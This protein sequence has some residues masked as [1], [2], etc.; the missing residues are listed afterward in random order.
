[1]YCYFSFFFLYILFSFL[2]TIIDVIAL[3]FD[4]KMSVID[5]LKAFGFAICRFNNIISSVGT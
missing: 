2:V 1:M 4:G 3:T 5:K